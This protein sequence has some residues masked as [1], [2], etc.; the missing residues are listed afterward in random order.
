MKNITPELIAQARAAKSAEELK[1]I[2][3]DVEITEEQA[4]AYF[5][6][7]GTNGVV[8]DDELELVAGG[9]GCNDGCLAKGVK[10]HVKN[11]SKC[12]K[13]SGT[14]G[15]VD[16]NPATGA[17]GVYCGKC[18]KHSIILDNVTIDDVEIL[19]STSGI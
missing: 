19:S 15:I 4:T 2:A 16:V 17:F 12:P 8:Q 1:A 7:L 10:V 18:G 9:D 14:L 6:Q 5:H 3:N 13:C 11:G